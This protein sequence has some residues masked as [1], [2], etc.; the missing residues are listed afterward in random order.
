MRRRHAAI[1]SPSK[2][3]GDQG[4]NVH[5][6]L[7]RSKGPEEDF[8]ERIPYGPND[9]SHKGAG[10]PRSESSGHGPAHSPEKSPGAVDGKG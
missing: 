8:A 2:K 3:S 1:T 6:Q 9:Q 10:R 4:K 7:G 5:Q